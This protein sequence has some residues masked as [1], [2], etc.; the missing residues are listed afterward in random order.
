MNPG[1]KTMFMRDHDPTSINGMTKSATDIF[2]RLSA[3]QDC[4]EKPKG[5]F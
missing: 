4:D 2:W 3:W 1:V 5:S